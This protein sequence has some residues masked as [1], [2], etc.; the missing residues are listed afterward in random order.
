MIKITRGKLPGDLWPWD[1]PWPVVPRL[2]HKFPVKSNHSLLAKDMVG[3]SVRSFIESYA[4]WKVHPIHRVRA[5][6][7]RD[8]TSIVDK[9]P[10]WKAAQKEMAELIVYHLSDSV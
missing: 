10:V 9:T 4:S 3:D 7:L 6:M 5:T 2:V 8:W 1:I